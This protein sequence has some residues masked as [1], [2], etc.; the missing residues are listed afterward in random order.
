M[1]NH[2]TISAVRSLCLSAVLLSMGVLPGTLGCSFGEPRVSVENPRGELSPVFLGVAAVYL[3]VR[4]D[5]GSD[6]LVNARVA[7]PEAIVE[8]HDVKNNRMVKVAQIPVPSRGALQLKPGGMHIMVF[9]LPRDMVKG[10]E[11]GMTLLFER[12]GERMVTVQLE[13]PGLSAGPSG[14]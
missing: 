3:T 10:S 6:R 8:L 2:H 9:N 7:V 12:S 5:G 13:A 14:G 11:F 1:Q 4:N